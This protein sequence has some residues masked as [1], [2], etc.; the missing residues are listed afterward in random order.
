MGG[1]WGNGEIIFSPSNRAPLFVVSAAGGE[2]RQLSTLKADLGEN[3]H[4]YPAFLPD[5]KHFLYL[6]RSALPENTGIWMGS[7]GAGPEIKKIATVESNF[8]YSPSGHLLFI[9]DSVLVAQEFDQQKGEMRGPYLPVADRVHYVPASK[10]AFFSVSNNGKTLVYLTGAV[11]PTQLSWID[12]SG[13]R[14]ASVGAPGDYYQVR[15]SPN[16]K[17]AAIVQPDPRSG[18]RDVWV[19]DLDTRLLSR[20]TS[21]PSNDWWP[22]WSPDNSQL[23][24]ASDRGGPG[25]YR[26][27]ITAGNDEE[28][29]PFSSG[30]PTDWAF[31]GQ[32]IAYES[33]TKETLGDL[34]VMPTSGGKPTPYLATKFNEKDGHFSPDGNWLAYSSDES[35][36]PEIYVRPFPNAHAGQWRISNAGGTDPRWRRDGEELFYVSSD[37][38]I[39]AVD[40]K[41]S[42]PLQRPVPKALFHVCSERYGVPMERQ[43]FDVAA[44]GRRFLAVCDSPENA[45]QRVTVIVNWAS[46]LK[47]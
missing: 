41:P 29:F 46:A 31:N 9:R 5:G 21:H 18:N 15:L 13:K 22:V 38:T 39:M 27:G 2:P 12:R 20:F 44:D 1:A 25:F 40:W 17:L 28:P 19:I 14:I 47:Q 4:R 32:W 6:A 34:W 36:S 26:K 11:R 23:A 8:S 45:E 30:M 3:S 24:F 10:R 33:G 37:G 16:G 43:S 35:G 42:T 7:L